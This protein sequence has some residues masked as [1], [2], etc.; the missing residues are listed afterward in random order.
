MLTV[1]VE[2]LESAY[3]RFNSSIRIARLA[4]PDCRVKIHLLNATDDGI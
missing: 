3:R 4:V 1:N 2:F